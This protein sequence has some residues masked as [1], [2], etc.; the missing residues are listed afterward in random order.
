M[1]RRLTA[2]LVGAVALATALVVGG[3]QLAGATFVSATTATA[4]VRAASDWTPPTVVLTAPPAVVQGTVTLTATAADADSAIAS[5]AVQHAGSGG[6]WTTLCTST[7]APYTCAWD[8]RT[9]ADGSHEL[10]AVATD[11]AGISATSATLTTRVA[12]TATVVLAEPTDVLRGTVPLA[13]TVTGAGAWSVR[14]EHATAGSTTWKPICTD[15]TAPYGCDWSTTGV[16]D[17]DYDLRAVAT[18]GTVTRT[19]SLVEDVTVDNTAPAVTM[20][21]PG[22][23]LRGTVLLTATASDAT[24]GVAAVTI[25]VAAGGTTVYRDVCTVTEEPYGCAF[26]TTKVADGSWSF[27]ALATDEAGNAST[28]AVVAGRTVDN[29]VSSVSVTDPGSNLRGTVTV[30]ANASSTAGVTSVRLQQAATGT[31]GWVDICADTTA[32]YSC[33]WDTTG[34]ADGGYDLRAVLVDG[35]GKSTSSTVVTNRRVDNSPLRA[36]GVQTANGGGTPGRLDAGDTVTFTYSGQVDLASITPSWNGAAL[37]VT[38][39]VRDGLLL[40]TGSNGDVLDVLRGSAAVRLGS[41]N[42]KQNYVGFLKTV[43]FAATMT[44]TT[45][46]VE[47][48]PVTTVTLVVGAQTSGNTPRQVTTASTTVW[49][50]S[51]GATDLAGRP[52]STAAVAEPGVLDREF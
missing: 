25:Q 7:T 23:P 50:P 36:L 11:T 49:T 16:A 45:T 24:S 52:T 8:S 42:L 4:T 35:A 30:A 9:V 37:P 28:S 2:A 19:S 48:M 12:N 44:A 1:P 46:T 5:V 29:T 39:R 47:G 21:N 38:V 51:A 3:P 15:A 34:V 27:R 22:S 6:T 20:Q 43:Q 32:P 41:V 18:A 33:T 14:I 10:R 17:G 40:G 31:T 26:D 13:V